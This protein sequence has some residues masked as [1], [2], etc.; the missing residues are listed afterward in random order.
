MSDGS[1]GERGESLVLCQSW[2]PCVGMPAPPLPKERGEGR[3][4]EAVSGTKATWPAFDH[5]PTLR[6]N[7]ISIP[8][9]PHTHTHTYTHIIIIIIIILLL[10]RKL[11]HPGARARAALPCW[12][13]LPTSDS[14]GHTQPSRRLR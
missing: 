5:Y 3:W 7:L 11:P 9:Q 8:P 14:Q 4:E 2:A 10:I 12:Y 1:W 13:H 6:H